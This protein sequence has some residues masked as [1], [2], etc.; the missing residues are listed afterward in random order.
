MQQLP[1]SVQKVASD[2]PSTSYSN[3]KAALT[4]LADQE[5]STPVCFWLTTYSRL[6]NLVRDQLS[7]DE[8]NAMVEAKAKEG[9]VGRNYEPERQHRVLPAEFDNEEKFNAWIEETFLHLIIRR[10]QEKNDREKD[11]LYLFRL[12]SLKYR[13]QNPAHCTKYPLRADLLMAL[14]SKICTC[15]LV[16]FDNLLNKSKSR[17]TSQ[18][19]KFKIP[20]VH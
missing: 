4:N 3:F 1:R 14:E 16:C 6:K 19:K 15:A 5:I 12:L 9:W 2:L 18:T 8:I 7:M 20:L 17:S 11:L 10:R 13:A